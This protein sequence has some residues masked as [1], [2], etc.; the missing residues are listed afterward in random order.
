MPRNYIKKRAANAPSKEK[1]ELVK[2][3]LDKGISIRKASKQIG[4]PPTTI[5]RYLE[6]EK[7]NKE[8]CK[9]GTKTSLPEE[10]ER[11]LALMLSIKSKW[12]YASSREEVKTLVH[13][14]VRSVKGTGTSVGDH[15][16]RYCKFKVSS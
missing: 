2:D 16:V 14:F 5:R 15:V 9:T 3:L 4:M 12:G 7:K 6:M 8:I 1:F 13:D 11:E 10:S